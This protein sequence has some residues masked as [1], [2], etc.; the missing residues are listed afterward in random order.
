[1]R[2]ITQDIQPPTDGNI[3]RALSEGLNAKQT[4]AEFDAMLKASVDSIYEAS[5]T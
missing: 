4:A 5:I 3:S 2:I 1:M